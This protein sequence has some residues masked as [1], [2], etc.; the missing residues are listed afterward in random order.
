MFSQTQNLIFMKRKYLMLFVIALAFAAC[1]DSAWNKAQK[2]NT[3]EAY[4]EYIENNPDSKNLTM[5]QEKIDSLLYE[6]EK[7]DWEIAK[8]S[9]DLELVIKFMEDYPE[10]SFI[11]DAKNLKKKL[12]DTLGEA[13]LWEKAISAN[14]YELF[15]EYL[16]K[17]P[18]GKNIKRALEKE[19]EL[20]RVVIKKEFSDIFSFFSG[21]EDYQSFF[22]RKHFDLPFSDEYLWETTGLGYFSNY[23]YIMNGMLEQFMAFEPIYGEYYGDFRYSILDG[24]LTTEFKIYPGGYS[25]SFYFKWEKQSGSAVITDFSAIKPESYM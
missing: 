3:V 8:K 13:E 16:D 20:A 23:R 18:K 17:Y 24:V 12:K 6:K 1:T 7:S 21:K 2:E 4:L 11:N 25:Y 15:L 5:A 10:G 19:E 9:N 14:S 22:S